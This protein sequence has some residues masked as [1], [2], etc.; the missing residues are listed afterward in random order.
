MDTSMTQNAATSGIIALLLPKYQLIGFELKGAPVG[1]VPLPERIA[2]TIY[3]DKKSLTLA[4]HPVEGVVQVSLTTSPVTPEPRFTAARVEEAK[5]GGWLP[6]VPEI[7]VD[8]ILQ[9]QRQVL[10][11]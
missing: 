2:A 9:H 11:R 6:N 8:W 10:S 4:D 1:D 5:P 7:T 3:T